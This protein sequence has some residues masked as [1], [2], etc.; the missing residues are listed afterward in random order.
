MSNET[1]EMLVLMCCFVF[2]AVMVGVVV[3]I[4]A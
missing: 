3:Y 1:H 4:S 2:V